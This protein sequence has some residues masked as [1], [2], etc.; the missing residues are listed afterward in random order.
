MK[1]LKEV[2]QAGTIE[3]AECHLDEQ[4]QKWGSNK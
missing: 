3:L 1:N 2:Y 4:E